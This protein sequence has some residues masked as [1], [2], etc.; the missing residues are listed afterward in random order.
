MGIDTSSYV[1]SVA[2]PLQ[3]LSELRQQ[4]VE[5]DLQVGESMRRVRQQVVDQSFRDLTAQV[6]RVNEIKQTAL[7][8]RGGGID[9]WA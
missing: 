4:Q 7:Q 1:T 8:A 9:V 5:T 2:S 6:E 3:Q